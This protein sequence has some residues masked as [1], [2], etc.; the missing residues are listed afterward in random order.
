MLDEVRAFS[1]F[2]TMDPK[3]NQM[4]D[5]EEPKLACC[6]TQLCGVWSVCG[7]WRVLRVA[8]REEAKRR[9]KTHQKVAHAESISGGP[10]VRNPRRICSL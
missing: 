5:A 8:R 7:A 6:R 1:A 3:G 4:K 10:L 9:E 2:V